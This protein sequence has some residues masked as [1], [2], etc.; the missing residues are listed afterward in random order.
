M[1]ACLILNSICAPTDTDLDWEAGRQAVAELEADE[2]TAD[3]AFDIYEF[4]LEHVSEKEADT[5]EATG[6][7]TDS[8]VRAIAGKLLADLESAVESGAT[9]RLTIGGYDVYISGGLSHGDS[10]TEEAEA[11]F[12]A[13]LNL[14]YSVL[15]AIGFAKDASQPVSR[16]NGSKGHVTDTDVVDAIA[17]GLHTQTDWGNDDL[18]WIPSLLD[19]VRPGMGGQT[20]AEALA[21]FRSTYGADPLQCNF[22][23][24]Y[25][26]EAAGQ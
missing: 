3:S 25:V 9:A 17:L 15:G 18:E 7:L 20:P 13:H 19:S 26:D 10:P 6:D 5:Y 23:S 22:L 4:L 14:P 1:G 21:T 2:F 12:Q 11:I 24:G 16:R 8:M